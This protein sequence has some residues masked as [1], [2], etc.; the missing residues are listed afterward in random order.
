MSTTICD[1]MTIIRHEVFGDDPEFPL[2]M[3]EC[4]VIADIQQ[5][6]YDL[7]EQAG[8]TQEQFAERVGVEPSVIDDLEEGDYDGDSMA[9]L[10]KIAVAFGKKC[11]LRLVEDR[12]SPHAPKATA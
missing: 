12:Y 2:L 4:T 8:L 9:M 7:R 3:A 10:L 6:V 1:A 5:A 11:E